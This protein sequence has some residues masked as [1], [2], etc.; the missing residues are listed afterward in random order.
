MIGLTGFDLSS[1]PFYENGDN[2][3][4][5]TWMFDR[6]LNFAQF[7][8]GTPSDAFEADIEPFLLFVSG[9]VNLFAD[10]TD[11]FST[12]WVFGQDETDFFKNRRTVQNIYDADYNFAQAPFLSTLTAVPGDGR[13]VLTWDTTSV[14]SFDRFSQ[15]F[16]FE[17]YRLY[18]GTNPLLSDARII[19]NV[20]GTPTFMR[21]IAQWDLENDI[22]GPITV[23][24]GEAVYDLGENSGLSFFYVDEDVRNGMT[25]YYAL[26]AYDRGI[27]EADGTPTIDPQENV[28]NISVN[29]AGNVL[30]VSQNA[31]IVVPRSKPAGFV[32]GAVN[33]DLSRVTEGVGYGSMNVQMIIQAPTFR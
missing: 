17:G 15:E 21:P 25:Y 20:D 28:F 30:G 4:D 16:D 24:E 9:P 11:F 26:V 31:A 27:Q 12:A 22:S 13:V 10:R 1:R 2:L 19:T 5:D 18:K 7:P 32:D 29:L 6:I 14:A 33:E 8:L 23:L 3:R